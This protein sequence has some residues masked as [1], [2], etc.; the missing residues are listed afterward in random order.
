MGKSVFFDWAGAAIAC[1]I[2]LCSTPLKANGF[3]DFDDAELI[4]HIAGSVARG[5]AC[6]S[7]ACGG[8]ACGAGCSGMLVDGVVSGQCR[9]CAPCDT[10]EASSGSGGAPD[11]NVGGASSSASGEASTGGGCH[12]HFGRVQVCLT[13]SGFVKIWQKTGELFPS[14][15]CSAIRSH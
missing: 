12:L 3:E 8:T 14:D 7:V 9:P 5:A 13:V 4:D 2:L 10:S 6:G 11:S 1:V 15:D